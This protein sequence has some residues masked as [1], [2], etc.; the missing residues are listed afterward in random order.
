VSIREDDMELLS[1]LKQGDVQAFDRFYERF[2]PL[3]FR[4][5]YQV[6]GDRMEAED[7]CHDVFLEVFDKAVQYDPSRGSLKTWLSIRTRCRA[8]DRMRQKRKIRVEAAP[9][10]RWELGRMPVET[11]EQCVLGKLEREALQRAMRT[12]PDSQRSAVYGTYYEFRT[13]K[14]LA[15]LLHRPLGTIKS[16][17]RYGLH[18]MKKQLLMQ[19]GHLS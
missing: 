8:L 12:L 5:A 2:V 9:E 16:L 3:V 17:V 14:E 19:D 15:V 13:Q 1:K 6:S 4:I 18:N 11:P 7:V 10:D